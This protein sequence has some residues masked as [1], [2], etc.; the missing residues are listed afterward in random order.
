MRGGV[1]MIPYIEE[2]PYRD[3]SRGEIHYIDDMGHTN[4]FGYRSGRP[5]I[6]ISNDNANRYSSHVTVIPLTSQEKKPTP[7]HVAIQCK[8]PS[9]ALCENIQMVAQ[10]KVGNY[11]RTCTKDEM[12]EIHKGVYYALGIPMPET[13]KAISDSPHESVDATNAKIIKLEAER[14]VY[15]KVCTQLLNRYTKPK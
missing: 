15:K 3:F 1:V 10:E 13:S 9:T 2:K 4:E 5:C 7:T 12:A 8:V 11:I 6:I 14:E